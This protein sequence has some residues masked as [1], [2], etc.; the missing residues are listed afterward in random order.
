MKRSHLV[1]AALLVATAQP[2]IANAQSVDYAALEE[3]MGE[4]VTTSVTG[5]PQTAS[6][7]PASLVI[8]TRDQ[9][10][11]SVARDVP[12]LLAAYA[13]IEVNRW[14]AGHSD[15]AVRGGVQT[16]NARLLVLVNGRQVYLDH[17]GMTNWNLLGIQVEEIQQIEL[18]RG[19]ASALFGFNAASGVVNIITV[20]PLGKAASA[21]T[22]EGG[23]NGYFRAAG[24]VAIPLSNTVGLSLSAGSARERELRVP[25]A[26]AAPQAMDVVSRSIAGTLSAKIGDRSRIELNGGSALNRQTE[27]LPSQVLSAQR[28]VADTIG[29]RVNRDTVW[30]SVTAHAYANRLNAIYGVQPT[31]GGPTSLNA[32]F[33]NRIVVGS[34]TSLV[35]LSERDTLR[36]GVEYRDNAIASESYIFSPEI[37]YRVVAASAMV[38]WRPSDRVSVTLAGRI[39]HLKLRQVG[40]PLMPAL[41]DA[42]DYDRS[43]TSPSFNAA[44]LIDLDEASQLR[45]NGGRGVQSPSL[46]DFALRA[47]IVSAPVPF[48]AFATG[49]PAINPAMIW[50]AELGYLRQITPALNVAATL[51]F[52]RVDG[53]I[54]TPGNEPI[55]DVRISASGPLIAARIGNAGAFE[56]RGIELAASGT[57]TPHLHWNAN[58]SWLDTSQDS[59]FP[60]YAIS[61]RDST[62]R[63]SAKGELSYRDDHWL[64]SARAQY[65]SATRQFAFSVAGD[66][67]AIPLADTLALDARLG[68]RV[69]SK[70]D[71]TVAGENLTA[72][73]AAWGSPIPAERRVRVGLSWRL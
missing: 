49:D 21:A 9:I 65:R 22:L 39:D 70:L 72:A 30:G 53:V 62:P 71:L 7:A 38:D 43:L 47:P 27:F 57:M 64:L 68:W 52:N 41:N 66:Q 19:P 29:V 60:A 11:R 54:A 61:P 32:R 56:T 24:S 3:A 36:L 51:F 4:P 14:T 2:A 59:F 26:F 6:A 34:L 44:L 50:S 13:G 46:V 48:P 31:V 25:Q 5:K 40:T 42:A 16:Y 18:V 28:F 10:A 55:Y 20:D 15:V 67:I 33:E 73:A 58:Y 37:G 63:H 45:I 35:R 23:T 17:Y 1:R 69:T 8:I 12:G